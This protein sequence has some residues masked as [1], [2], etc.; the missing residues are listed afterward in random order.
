MERWEVARWVREP[1][2]R[3][4]ERKR[5]IGGVRLVVGFKVWVYLTA[6]RWGPA[7]DASALTGLG[8]RARDQGE[9]AT[10][11]R[12]RPGHAGVKAASP[13]RPRSAFLGTQRRL[14]FCLG[15][16]HTDRRSIHTSEHAVLLFQIEAEIAEH[17]SLK[18]L[19]RR[20]LGACCLPPKRR[21][22]PRL[23]GSPPLCG[24]H[25]EPDLRRRP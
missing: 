8:S 1:L 20:R 18:S 13:R 4:A 17:A 11:K 7:P 2:R 3:E 9:A 15:R 12:R 16:K 10:A 21:R 23:A 25:P 6:C 19:L 24:E 5:K 22:R 14:R